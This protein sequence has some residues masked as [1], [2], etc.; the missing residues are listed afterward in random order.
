VLKGQCIRS[1]AGLYYESKGEFVAA[2][3]ALEEHRWLNGSLGRNGRTF[4]RENYV[5]EIIERKYLEMLARLTAQPEAGGMSPLPGW[6]ERRANACAPAA[7]VLKTIP[8]GPALGT[9]PRDRE[10]PAFQAS[11][12]TQADVPRPVSNAGIQRAKS[13]RRGAPHRRRSA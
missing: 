8:R 4:F 12:R 1:N 2:L 6:L 10:M 5:W 9:A 3:R 13:A 11:A 7:A